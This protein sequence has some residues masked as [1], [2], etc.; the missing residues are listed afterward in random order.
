[1]RGVTVK[2]KPNGNWEAR[3]RAGGRGT[4]YFSRTFT[5]KRDADTF[6]NEIAR[7]KQ[8]HGVVD[9]TVGQE[10][11]REFMAEVWWRLHAIPNLAPST[12]DTTKRVWANHVLPHLGDYPLREITPAVVQDWRAK[13]T[14]D[15]AGDPTVIKAMGLLQGILTMA[16][17]R[18]RI[19]AN[20]VAPV[21]KPRQNTDRVAQPLAPITVERL[22]AALGAHT[23]QGAALAPAGAMLALTMAYA[24]TRPEELLS[25]NWSALGKRTLQVYATKTH[26]PRVIEIV[27]S[28]AADL[29]A[30][31]TELGQPDPDT[32]IIPRRD[33]DHW[34][35]TDY[36][37]W[38]R[39]V[40]RRAIHAIGLNGDQRPYRL[41]HTFVSLRIAEGRDL[42]WIAE[43]AGHS[44][45]V[46]SPTTPASCASSPTNRAYP[47]TNRSA[48]PARN[49]SSSR[50]GHDVHARAPRVR[51]RRTLALKRPSAYRHA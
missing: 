31:R 2:Q 34:K 8:L 27:P 37:N 26:R 50:S 38:R 20:P 51:T 23:G 17:L 25:C 3:W 35:R 16:V 46:L 41:R 9:L 4:R 12:R 22:V 48:A 36:Q 29:G 40:Y 45:A 18:G 47:W 5:R 15:G 24:G 39:Q 49:S 7:T 14:A 30:W 21:R 44:I 13:L 6:A 11:L 1:M 43:Q 28:L 19:P 32:P 42:A 10:P 33:G